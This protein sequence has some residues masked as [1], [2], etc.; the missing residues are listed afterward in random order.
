MQCVICS[1]DDQADAGGG[2]TTQQFDTFGLI[3]AEFDNGQMIVRPALAQR[4][5]LSHATGADALA[6]IAVF[7]HALNIECDEKFFLDD[8]D[9]LS[10]ELWPI[11]NAKATTCGQA[12]SLSFKFDMSR[13]GHLLV[14]LLVAASL[15]S[16]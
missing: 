3:G 14:S 12:F 11:R 10:G 1:G 4:Q 2:E 6:G 8:E 15:P 7:Q 9:R 16:P 5:G 13:N